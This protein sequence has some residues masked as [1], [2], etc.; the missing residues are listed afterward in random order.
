MKLAVYWEQWN[1]GPWY[2]CRRAKRG[3][4]LSLSMPRAVKANEMGILG[5]LHV[6]TRFP[7]RF[8]IVAD[9]TR[10]RT[11]AR[12]GRWRSASAASSCTAAIAA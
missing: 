1:S 7:L 9:P 12:T 6:G 8:R 2:R 3:R 10:E 4:R 5:D 11:W